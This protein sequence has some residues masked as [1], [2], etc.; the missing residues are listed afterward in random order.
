MKMSNVKNFYN[1]N[2]QAEWDRLGFRHRSEFDNSL[3]AILEF[4]PPAP[5]DLIDIG[6]GPGRYSIALAG[7]SYNVTLVDLAQA[8][9]DMAQQKAAEAGVELRNCIHANALDL[10]A[11]PEASF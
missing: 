9:L 2:A 3:R 11:F 8:N 7:K 1:E 10:T 4:L 6:G 5:A